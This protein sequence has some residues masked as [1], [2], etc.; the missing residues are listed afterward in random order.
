MNS[1]NKKCRED[2]VYFVEKYLGIEI[3]KWQKD[4]IK[5]LPKK[6]KW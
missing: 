1:E 3:S 4:Y 5:K 6:S 2:I